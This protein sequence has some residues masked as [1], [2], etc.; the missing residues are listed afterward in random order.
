[1]AR[2]AKRHDKSEAQILLRW[3][4]ELGNIVITKSV[5][6]E[7]IRSN[8]EIFDFELTNGDQTEIAALNTGV[9]TGPDPAVYGA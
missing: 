4:F 7:R 1:V 6:P 5:T 9:R 8:R 2:I 3:N